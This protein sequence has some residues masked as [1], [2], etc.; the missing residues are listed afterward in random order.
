MGNGLIILYL[1]DCAK[2]GR[3]MVDRPVFGIRCKCVGVLRRQIRGDEPRHESVGVSPEAVEPRLPR[4][5]S[6]FRSRE[7][8]RKPT[9]V[10]GMNNPRRSRELWLRNSA[11]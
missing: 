4:K 6:K 1:C 5:A 9:Q 11:N 2:K 10:D 3:R 8:Y 7:P